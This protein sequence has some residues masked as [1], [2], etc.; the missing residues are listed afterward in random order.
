MRVAEADLVKMRS[1]FKP[2]DRR[3]PMESHITESIAL[4]RFVASHMAC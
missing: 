3:C 2:P 1:P 4:V